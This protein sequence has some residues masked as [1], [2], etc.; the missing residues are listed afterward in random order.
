ME[1]SGNKR[2]WP[3][4]SPLV[5]ASSPKPEKKKTKHESRKRGST[6]ARKRKRNVGKSLANYINFPKEFK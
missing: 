3:L 5:D 2:G 6:R 1:H 4:P